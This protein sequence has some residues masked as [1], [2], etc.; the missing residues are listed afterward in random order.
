MEGGNKDTDLRLRFWCQQFDA[1]AS[2][3]HGT[4]INWHKAQLRTYHFGPHLRAFVSERGRPSS[5]L[6]EYGKLLTPSFPPA[7]LY[8]LGFSAMNCALDGA[9]KLPLCRSKLILL[10]V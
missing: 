5:W 8:K 2:V 6:E 9:V 1:F 3:F 10:S 4:V 7:S